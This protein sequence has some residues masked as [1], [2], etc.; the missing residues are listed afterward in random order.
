MK[1]LCVILLLLVQVIGAQAA[2]VF[3][4]D[5]KP[6][7]EVLK[8]SWNEYSLMIEQELDPQMSTAADPRPRDP[9]DPPRRRE[10]KTRS[11]PAGDIQDKGYQY[12]VRIKNSSRTKTIKSIDWDYVLIDPNNP[13]DVSHHRF[14]T[15][16]KIEPGKDEQI[17]V[18]ST[19]PPVQV[20]NV[21]S[22][23]KPAKPTEKIVVMKVEYTD[24]ST[25]EQP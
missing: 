23:D 16:K 15:D 14:H 8:Y 11:H 6:E 25:W 3:Q 9:F 20:I 7:V 12:K 18:S 21:K 13:K 10:V 4:D 19:V 24:G 5:P 17:T 1:S 22:I 2:S